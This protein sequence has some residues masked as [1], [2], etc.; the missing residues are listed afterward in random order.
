MSGNKNL[1]EE[2]RAK[3]E[4]YMRA[5]ESVGHSAAVYR[6]AGGDVHILA[7]SD[8]RAVLDALEAA[9]KENRAV[10]AEAWFAGYGKGNLDGYFGTR[11]RRRNSPYADLDPRRLEKSDD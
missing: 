11:D 5:A 9:E 6:E 10:K 4:R 7:F 8:L 2:A 3:V 1:I